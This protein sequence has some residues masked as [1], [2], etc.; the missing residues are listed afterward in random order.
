VNNPTLR[1]MVMDK[2]AVPTNTPMVRCWYCGEILL[3]EE[4]QIE[5]Q[6]PRSRGG[7]GNIE[8][9]VPSCAS[10]NCRKGSR[11]LEEYRDYVDTLFYNR[12][13]GLAGSLQALS[14]D[15][16]GVWVDLWATE[17]AGAYGAR[18]V[19]FGEH[20]PDGAQ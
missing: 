16:S 2:T 10:C 9:L 4:A 18:I 14:R 20:V 11:N 6:T 3:L 12:M 8:N 17:C 1:S 15:E 19:F 5:H 13:R 7:T